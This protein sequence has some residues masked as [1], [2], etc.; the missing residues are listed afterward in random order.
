MLVMS[1]FGDGENGGDGAAFVVEE[2][3]G[4]EREGLESVTVSRGDRWCWEW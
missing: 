2:M 3:V 4:C 1:S